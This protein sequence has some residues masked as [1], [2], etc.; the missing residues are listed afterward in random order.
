MLTRAAQIHQAGHM[1]P[2]GRV[3]ET[4]AVE[5]VRNSVRER[6]K[7]KERERRYGKRV[8]TKTKRKDPE[9]HICFLECVDNQHTTW[10]THPK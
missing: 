9:N 5:R 3:F 4:P 8:E 7:N 1:R 10:Q 6:P 2:A